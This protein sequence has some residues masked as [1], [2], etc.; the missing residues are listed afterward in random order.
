MGDTCY[1]FCLDVRRILLVPSRES[2]DTI[3]KPYPAESG[4]KP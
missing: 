1:W 2:V 4:G 3:R